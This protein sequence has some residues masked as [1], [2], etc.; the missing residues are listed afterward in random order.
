MVN[1]SFY[2]RSEYFNKYVYYIFINIKDITKNIAI[3]LCGDIIQHSTAT[4][5]QFK[6]TCIGL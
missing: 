4:V 5:K 3:G 1:C 6:C 2:E